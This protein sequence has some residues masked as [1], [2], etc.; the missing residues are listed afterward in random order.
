MYGGC[1]STGMQWKQHLVYCNQYL[2]HH[3]YNY[4][5]F[6]CNHFT[7]WFILYYSLFLWQHCLSTLTYCTVSHP[8]PLHAHPA[9]TIQPT[10]PHFPSMHKKL[11]CILCLTLLPGDHVLNMNITVANA[12]RRTMHGESSS[13]NI[14]TVVRN[15]SV[16]FSF[17][18]MR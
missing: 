17:T 8:L 15:E 16:G 12:S 11:N 5:T 3:K 6:F 2:W 7:W 9:L 13:D 4:K 10:V 18:N 1:I 14:A